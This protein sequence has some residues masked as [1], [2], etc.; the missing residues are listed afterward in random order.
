MNIGTR[1]DLQSRVYK[2]QLKPVELFN[3]LIEIL[4]S[5]ETKY[6]ERALLR[7]RDDEKE[8]LHSSSTNYFTYIEP[9][10]KDKPDT[11]FA[12][13]L[14]KPP[15]G[16]RAPVI[17]VRSSNQFLAKIPSLFKFPFERERNPEWTNI[18]VSSNT[19]EVLKEIL[20]SEVESYFASPQG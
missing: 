16:N 11:I 2:D 13:A 8:L 10:K 20:H 12:G 6:S 18:I 15:R 17:R 5:L 1:I 14:E 3:K 9:S 19:I 7:T 4:D